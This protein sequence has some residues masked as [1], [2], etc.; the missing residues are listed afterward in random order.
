M[1]EYLEGTISARTAAG[2]VVDV[3]GVGYE[4]RTPLG[5]RL[6]QAGET[7]RIWTHL[8]VREDNHTLFGFATRAEREL[9]RM[10]L[11]VRGVG[12]SMALAIL[13]ALDRTE[14][15]QGLSQRD[16]KVFT[17]AKG[18]GRKTAEQIVLDLGDRAEEFAAGCEVQPGVIVPATTQSDDP[19]LA[20][21][22]AAL[23]SIGYA[24]KD[25]RARVEAAAEELGDGDLEALVRAAIRR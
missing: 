11:K 8:V 17:R 12:P 2:V 25:A 10:L 21:A 22:T 16:P 7:A 20:D 6:P 4:L 13:S 24:E 3:G 5:A 14:L 23:V 18:V 1:Y 15:V 19:A 9:F